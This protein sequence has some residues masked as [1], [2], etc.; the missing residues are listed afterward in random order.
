M[1]SLVLTIFIFIG[2]MG[3][4]ALLFGG[5]VVIS[6]IRFISRS[7]S[8]GSTALPMQRMGFGPTCPNDR[9]RAANPAGAQFCRRCGQNLGPPQRAAAAVRRAAMW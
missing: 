2:V 1:T 5:W 9:C 4:T 6:I 8:G 3:V 7:F